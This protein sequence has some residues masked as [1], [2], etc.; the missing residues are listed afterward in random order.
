MP[1][2]YDGL[3]PIAFW[4]SGVAHTPS[5][6]LENLYVPKFS[7]TR[8]TR[9]AT[10]GSCFAQNL[11]RAI[12]E[13]GYHYVDAE[14]PPPNFHGAAAR[15]F[16]FEQF[17]ARYGNIY[18]ARQL[19]Q[20]LEELDGEREFG[21]PVWERNGR[22]YDSLRPAVEPDGLDTP[23][24][25]ARHREQHLERVAQ[26]IDNADVFVFTLGLTEAWVENSSGRVLPSAPGVIAGEYDPSLY[27]FLNFGPTDVI[28]DLE[29][30][31]ARLKR[32][33]SAIRLLLT[34]SPVPL[35]ATASGNHVYV[36]TSYSKAVLRGAA[37]WLSDKYDD[38]DY[39]PSY[40]FVTN[41]FHAASRF[42]PNLRTVSPW[43]VSA[44]MDIFFGDAPEAD[45]CTGVENDMDAEGA[46]DTV[47]ED[48]MLNAFAP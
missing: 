10:A 45:L 9:F 37:G 30:V 17:S 18:T 8:E 46:G 11:R 36:A 43:V 42:E 38:V 41:A 22:F 25:I 19:L 3:P 34:V 15:R 48:A 1:T 20:L 26:V 12:L 29:S 35:T 24:S 16:G 31:L 32:R 13:R 23:A 21:G 33:N 40:E 27:S 28:A 5:G 2:P 6:G 39:F 4:S 14:T 44:V 47:C 7:I